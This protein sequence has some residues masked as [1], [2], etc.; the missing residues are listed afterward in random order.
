MEHT[1]LELATAGVADHTLAQVPTALL[2]WKSKF[3]AVSTPLSTMIPT[4][5]PVFGLI[6]TLVPLT[7]NGTPRSSAGLPNMS[8]ICRAIFPWVTTARTT[9]TPYPT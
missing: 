5:A 2:V 1:R 4:H 6:P 3:H 7:M 8:Q 9:T